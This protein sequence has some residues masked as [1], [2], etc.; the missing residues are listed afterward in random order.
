ML[1][2]GRRCRRADPELLRLVR[3][4]E[5]RQRRRGKAHRGLRGHQ[6]D[7]ARRRALP[8]RGRRGRGGDRG[9]QGRHRC[10]GP[11]LHGRDR[12]AA[13]VPAGLRVHLRVQ[14]QAEQH[15]LPRKLYSRRPRAELFQRHRA[16]RRRGHDGEDA[17]QHRRR[18]RALGGA[19]PGHCGAAGRRNGRGARGRAQRGARR[20][21]QRHHAK[22]G[23]AE[24]VRHG[25]D[26]AQLWPARRGA[27]LRRVVGG[28]FHLSREV[29]GRP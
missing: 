28:G 17:R 13:R 14:R 25:R 29:P 20:A 8:L 3:R 2:E 19:P 26:G 18:A 22:R 27:G 9:R 23:A 1:Q 5:A 4:G 7:G 6:P 15:G 21:H 11:V 16:G 24:Q 12:G 10:G